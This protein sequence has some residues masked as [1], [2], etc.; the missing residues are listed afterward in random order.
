MVDCWLICEGCWKVELHVCRILLACYSMQPRLS[1][2]ATPSFNVSL[3]S[4]SVHCS[5]H[6]IRVNSHFKVD[7]LWWKAFDAS[8]D[9]TVFFYLPHE[10]KIQFVCNALDTWRQSWK[11]FPF[12]DD[13]GTNSMSIHAWRIYWYQQIIMVSSMGIQSEEAFSSYSVLV[14]KANKRAWLLQNFQTFL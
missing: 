14:V 6:H 9:S 8:W 7:L 5:Y 10:S 1:T 3:T 4:S 13:R 12:T 2:Q 11:Y